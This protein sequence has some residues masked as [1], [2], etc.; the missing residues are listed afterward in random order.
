MLEILEMHDASPE[1]VKAFADGS[2]PAAVAAIKEL[3]EDNDRKMEQTKTVGMFAYHYG[4]A[5]A[6]QKAI[7]IIKG[8]R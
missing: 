1:E 7:N 4:A 2:D 6:Y 3:I 5:N 8:G